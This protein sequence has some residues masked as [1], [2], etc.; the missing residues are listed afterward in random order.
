MEIQGIKINWLGHNS[1]KLKKDKVI[2]IDPYKISSKSKADLILITHDHYD[3]FSLEDIQ[4]ISKKSTI[5]IAPHSFKDSLKDYNVQLMEPEESIVVED[6]KIESL[7]AYN[8]DKEFHKKSTNNLG[9]ILTI[10]KTRIYHAGDTDLIPEMNHVDVNI[11]FLPISGKYVMDAEEAAHAANIIE[12]EV[13]IPMHYG[14]IIGSQ[15]DAESFKRLVDPEIKV[16]I[17]K[18]ENI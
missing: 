9:Y 7:Y 16:L 5:I 1:F 18:K 4:K 3:H 13:V 10:D 2:Y 6:I 14:S 17:L 11:A 12:P 15:Q 8:I